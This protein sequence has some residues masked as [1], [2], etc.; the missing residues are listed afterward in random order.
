MA[1]PY[2]WLIRILSAYQ[3]TNGRSASE[4]DNKEVRMK[5]EE[6]WVV[7]YPSPQLFLYNDPIGNTQPMAYIPA[8][9]STSFSG[10][11]ILSRTMH[12]VLLNRV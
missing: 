6:I 11:E 9:T 12:I 5:Y 2:S 4:G 8:G 7:Q 10:I 1:V 3:S